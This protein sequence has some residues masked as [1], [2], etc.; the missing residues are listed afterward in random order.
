VVEITSLLDE[1]IHLSSTL[2]KK[3][4]GSTHILLKEIDRIL[5]LH[6]RKKVAKHP[7]QIILDSRDDGHHRV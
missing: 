2:L 1:C 4:S 7:H 3:D 5:T 6:Q